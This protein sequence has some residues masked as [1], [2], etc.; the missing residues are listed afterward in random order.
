MYRNN[1]DVVDMEGVCGTGRGVRDDGSFLSLTDGRYVPRLEFD[2]HILLSFKRL[3]FLL[4]PFSKLA[5]RPHSLNSRTQH[6]GLS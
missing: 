4:C 3:G 5:T 6:Q 1:L 2:T